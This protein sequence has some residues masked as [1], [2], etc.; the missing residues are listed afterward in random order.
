MLLSNPNRPSL[1]REPSLSRKR[2][3]PAHMHRNRRRCHSAFLNSSWSSCSRNS[4]NLEDVQTGSKYLVPI[5]W[6]RISSMISW[7]ILHDA[8]VAYIWWGSSA[9][10]RSHTRVILNS[11]QDHV[12]DCRLQLCN[13]E[14]FRSGARRPNNSATTYNAECLNNEKFL[15]KPHFLI[16]PD[17]SL[18]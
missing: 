14:G 5:T 11:S 8:G 17:S 15:P 16:L 12:L 4:K 18:Q 1:H 6:K 7:G 2:F 3:H 13:R 10:W 9:D